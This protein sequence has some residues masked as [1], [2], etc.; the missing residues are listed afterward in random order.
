MG[1][2]YSGD[3]EGKFWFGVQSSDDPDFFGGQTSEP[4]EIGYAFTTDDVPT[5]EQGLTEC[6]EELGEYR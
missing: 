6:R 4:S 5:I 2:Y 3:I 1:R